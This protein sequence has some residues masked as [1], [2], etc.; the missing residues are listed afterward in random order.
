ML[1]NESTLRIILADDDEDDRTFFSEAIAELKMTNQLTLLTTE[2]TS[3][4]TC[5][6]LIR[7]C[8]TSFSWI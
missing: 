7:S 2:K 1:T 3:W 8:R 6:I 5:T 4:N